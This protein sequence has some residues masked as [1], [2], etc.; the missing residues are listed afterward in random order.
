MENAKDKLIVDKI[1]R[2][3]EQKNETNNTS[4]IAKLNN[5]IKSLESKVQELQQQQVVIWMKTK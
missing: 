2:L 4:L 3:E 5:E 1:N